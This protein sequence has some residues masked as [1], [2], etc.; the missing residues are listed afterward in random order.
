MGDKRLALRFNRARFL[1]AGLAA[2][3]A[4][5]AN[6]ALAL[7]AL[8]AI[9]TSVAATAAAQSS[10]YSRPMMQNALLAPVSADHRVCSIH[11]TPE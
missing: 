3:A 5:A 11:R 4:A 9:A 1:E 10:C 2:G 6:A 8:A 7:A